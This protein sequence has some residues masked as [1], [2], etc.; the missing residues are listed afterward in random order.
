MQN[1]LETR[2]WD[3]SGKA[4]YTVL[5]HSAE[6]NW[7]RLKQRSNVSKFAFGMNYLASE[8][9]IVEAIQTHAQLLR[10][11]PTFWDP[12][13]WSP[14]SPLS[15]GF[16]RQEYWSGMPYP[17]PR[18]LLH[19]GIEPESPVAPAVQ[20]DSLPLSH[21]GCPTISYCRSDALPSALSCVSQWILLTPVSILLSPRMQKSYVYKACLLFQNK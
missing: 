16:S 21:R 4:L 14:Q 5:G 15:M 3:S 17:S 7:K 2:V 9:S 13:N 12:M 1:G 20:T 6:G 18:Y 8:R 19:P 10:L 11:C